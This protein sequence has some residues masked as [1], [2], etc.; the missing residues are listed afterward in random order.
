MFGSGVIAYESC[1]RIERVRFTLL[2]AKRIAGS[3]GIPSKMPGYSYGL[4][5]WRCIAGSRLS[6]IPGSVCEGCFAKHNFYQW[7]PARVARSRRQSAIRHPRWVEA[8]VRLITH[9]CSN[10][11]WFRW[12]D[13]G[14]LQGPGP[15]PGSARWRSA[16]RTYGTGCRPASTPW[17]KRIEPAA[18]GFQRT[19]SSASRLTWLARDLSVCPSFFAGFR[20][21]ANPVLL[22]QHERGLKSHGAP[23][24]GRPASPDRRAPFG[25]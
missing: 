7:R 24:H 12:H 3:L 13:S 25:V 23:R 21:R 22:V 16:R 5:A 8:M 10:E 11:P 4:D 9:Y 20:R 2:E 6:E 1:V 17:S 14:D 18:G 19:S 15:S